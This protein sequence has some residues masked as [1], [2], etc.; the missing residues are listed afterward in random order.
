M[1]R[2][3]IGLATFVGIVAVM[4]LLNLAGIEWFKF[5]GTRQEDARR[6]VFEETKSYNQG[7]IQDLANLYTEYTMS[8]DMEDRSALVEVVKMKYADLNADNID[9][10]VLRNWLINTRGF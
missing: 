3:K 7:A 2:I 4:F 5:F 9:N 1:K 8:N 10:D 6:R